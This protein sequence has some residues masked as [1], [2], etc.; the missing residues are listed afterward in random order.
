MTH[1]SEYTEYVMKTSKS[2]SEL[3]DLQIAR[4]IYAT[5]A[6]LVAV[7]HPEFIKLIKM[8]RPGYL[9]PNR[10]DVGNKLLDKVQ[11]SLLDT[12][13]QTLQ[14]KLVSLS[15][16]GWS[17]VHNE[18]VICVSVTTD[19]GETFLT[20]TID[21]SEHSHTSGYLV[22]IAASA[23]SSCE[24]NFKCQIHSVV[25]NNAANMAKMRRDLKEK[26]PNEVLTYGCAAHLL[27]LLAQDVQIPSVKE[28]VVQIVKYFRKTHL[29]AARYKAAGG[30]SLVIPHEIR[31]NTLTDCLDS[32]ISNWPILVKVVKNIVMR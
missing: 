8:L 22:E 6:P 21:T 14:D 19:K 15:L 28:Q 26:I 12:C 20:E 18:P 16:D 7:E 9:P 1:I 29:P 31:W 32:Y 24:E 5:N 23:I 17:N 25:T 4:Y 11:G 3:L 30:K 27:N 10:H 13:N 2:E